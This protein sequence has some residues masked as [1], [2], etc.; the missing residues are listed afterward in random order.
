M[1]KHLQFT[2]LLLCLL[3]THHLKAQFATRGSARPI[4][5]NAYQLTNLLNTCE[6]GRNA[7]MWHKEPLNLEASFEISFDGYFGDGSESPDG[8][9]F[10]INSGFD[11]N[12]ISSSRFGSTIG[13]YFPHEPREAVFPNSLVIEFD[14]LANELPIPDK[15]YGLNDD[16]IRQAIGK[17]HTVIARNSDT[18]DTLSRRVVIGK[19]DDNQRHGVSIKWNFEQKRMSL[20]VDSRSI[21]DTVVNLNPLI[22]R[23]CNMW[24]FT[25]ASGF[26][27][28][29][30]IIYTPTIKYTS[31][32]VV[33]MPPADTTKKNVV[34]RKLEGKEILLDST[35]CQEKR[36]IN[37]NW[38]IG[39]ESNITKYILENSTDSTTYTNIGSVSAIGANNVQNQNT[40]YAYTFTHF[41]PKAGINYYR[42]L[43]VAKDGTTNIIGTDTLTIKRNGGELTLSPNPTSGILSIKQAIQDDTAYSLYNAAGQLVKTG[44][45]QNGQQELDIKNLASGIY[46]LRIKDCN[47]QQKVIK[48]A[49]ID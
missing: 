40:V 28:N 21:I 7:A 44:I 1:T 38:Y 8:F 3:C 18:Y 20:T 6:S 32:T 19:L 48:I 26:L 45:I 11:T 41:N 14:G 25:A 17:T 27:C 13:Y 2:L 24:G 36:A 29:N 31:D 10:V 35:P 12:R 22:C 37:L 42:L 34:V 23:G 39:N 43:S 9:C 47:G 4:G 46:F 16:N 49:K 30:Q 33:V 15:R 5:N